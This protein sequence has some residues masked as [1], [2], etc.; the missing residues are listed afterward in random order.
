MLA[1]S[2]AL[3]PMLLVR[4]KCRLMLFRGA[5][6]GAA[7]GPG[8][9]A[10]AGAGSGLGPG[11][12]TFR[13]STG[14]VE[15]V[16]QQ[17]PCC[18]VTSPCLWDAAAA[19]FGVEEGAAPS[20]LGRDAYVDAGGG[21]GWGIGRGVVAPG[22][23]RAEAEAEAEASLAAVCKDPLVTTQHT[24]GQAGGAA[25][26]VLPGP[27]CWLQL[28]ASCLGPYNA[29]AAVTQ[30]LA[31]AVA[32]AVAAN[33]HAVQQQ[34]NAI[35]RWGDVRCLK[36]VP[37]AG[38]PAWALPVPEVW[39]GGLAAVWGQRLSGLTMALLMPGL[40]SWWRGS[41]DQQSAQGCLGANPYCPL[42]CTLAALDLAASLLQPPRELKLAAAA[43]AQAGG[44]REQLS[45]LSSDDLAR[46]GPDGSGPRLA[47]AGAGQF[48]A[49]VEES[50]AGMGECKA[51][52]HLQGRGPL[53][54]SSPGCDV[55]RRPLLL[56]LLHMAGAAAAQV[57]QARQQEVLVSAMWSSDRL[58]R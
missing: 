48:E 51:G 58:S 26:W 31:A 38:L 42:S 7:A 18:W 47:L 32:A 5:A 14:V 4:F 56:L 3:D 1:A 50:G 57:R 2:A 23:C 19:I 54:G 43:E 8:A 34:Y 40:P 52:G 13:S 12:S 35:T 30:R 21:T 28:P 17:Q 24:G 53:G 44:L 41:L 16:R 27:A 37:G 11:V 10:G 33:R 15:E 55:P 25:A 6:T 36:G 49:G 29:P 45:V 39:A 20:G 22:T 46:G 9:G